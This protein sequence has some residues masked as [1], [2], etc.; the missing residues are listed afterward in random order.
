VNADGASQLG[1]GEWMDE[2][3][4]LM[5]SQTGTV[6]DYQLHALLEE[7]FATKSARDVGGTMKY[8]SPDSTLC[9]VVGGSDGGGFEWRAG[10]GT[11]HLA[12]ITTL[13]L[14]ADG[15]IT[16]ITPVYDSRQVDPASRRSLREAS[17][18]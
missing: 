2:R 13:E 6:P 4:G 9:H 1:K 10:P 7:F 5:E 16:A 18:A 3:Q 14:D 17:F 12:G 11:N 15:L 8:F